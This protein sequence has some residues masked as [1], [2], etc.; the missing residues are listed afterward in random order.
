MACEAEQDRVTLL[1]DAYDKWLTTGGITGTRY[2]EKQVT[3][4]PIDGKA[5]KTELDRAK[6]ALAVC[7]GCSQRKRR[8]L[9]V[10]PIG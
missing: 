4:G 9:H 3:R 1:Q 10:T 5:L 2:G 7:Q 6:D 8:I